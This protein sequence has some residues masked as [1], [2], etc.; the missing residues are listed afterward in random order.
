VNVVKLIA[1]IIL[2]CFVAV[3]FLAAFWALGWTDMWAGLVSWALGTAILW[4]VW[5]RK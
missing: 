1:T 2:G 5:G 3:P 4:Y